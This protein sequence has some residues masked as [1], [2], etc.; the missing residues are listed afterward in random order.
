M[1][2]ILLAGES[3]TTTSTHT[4]GF[5]SFITSTYAEGAGPFLKALRSAGHEV[6]YLPNHLAAESFPRTE[7]E[8]NAFD[9]V[10]L[11]DIGANTLLLSA[12]TFLTGSR[13]PN[14]LDALASWVRAG[15]ALLMVGGYLSFQG[16]EAKAN[17]VNTAIA[18]I[19]PVD[20]EAGD[21]REET[22]QGVAPLVTDPAHPV[23]YGLPVVWPAVLGYQ[24]VRARAGAD[25]LVEVDGRP[26][27]ITG[28]AGEGRVMAFTSDMGPHWLPDAFMAWSGYDT[29]W[30]QSARWLCSAPA[31]AAADS[32]EAVYT[33]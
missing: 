24:R 26:L 16:I 25:V 5:D 6:T 4:K 19:L 33:P 8:L 27:A 29:F 13:S 21:D 7:A 17:Y 1:S 12:T 20:M 22:P 30:Q 9:L 3:W 10:V 14:R 23:T 2:R 28:R 32:R 15:G 11:S 31:D 18:Q